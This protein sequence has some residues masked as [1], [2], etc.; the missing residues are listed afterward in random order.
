MYKRQDDLESTT[1]ATLASIPGGFGLSIWL[2]ENGLEAK[3]F[4]AQSFDENEWRIRQLFTDAATVI[5]TER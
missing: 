2:Y 5:I 3:W 4:F 1:K